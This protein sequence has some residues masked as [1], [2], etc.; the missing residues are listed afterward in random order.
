MTWSRVQTTGGWRSSSAD[1]ISLVS[2]CPTFAVELAVVLLPSLA[3]LFETK[4][5]GWL[6]FSR[7]TT[8]RGASPLLWMKLAY[9]T[10]DPQDRE[11]MLERTFQDLTNKQPVAPSELTVQM[12]RKLHVKKAGLRLEA[13]SEISRMCAVSW[14]RVIVAFSRND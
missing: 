2:N 12:G 6:L 1:F 7:Q 13:M 14:P 5:L 9:G 4:Q 11:A 8:C 3:Y 10:A